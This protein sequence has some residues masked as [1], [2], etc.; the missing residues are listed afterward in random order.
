MKTC[1]RFNNSL[2]NTGTRNDT[3]KGATTFD[4][5]MGQDLEFKISFPV[6]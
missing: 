4:S 5:I 3:I 2:E 6:A 1:P